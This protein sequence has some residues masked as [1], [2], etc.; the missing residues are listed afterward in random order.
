MFTTNVNESN[1]A[2]KHSFTNNYKKR[3]RFGKA[4]LTTN[5]YPK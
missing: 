5:I 2:L 3:A 1:S 4:G